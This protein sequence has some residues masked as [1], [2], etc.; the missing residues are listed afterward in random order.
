MQRER[1]CFLTTYHK[2]SEWWFYNNKYNL[3]ELG[4]VGGFNVRATHW[5]IADG[6]GRIP[7]DSPEACY[8]INFVKIQVIYKEMF[9]CEIQFILFTDLV[10][11]FCH[12]NNNIAQ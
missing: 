7:K 5:A 11:L 2:S 8:H 4:W 3:F 10:D 9:C 6:L 1:A 12:F